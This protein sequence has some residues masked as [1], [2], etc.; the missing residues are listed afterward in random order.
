MLD[1]FLMA[2]EIHFVE[3]KHWDV[4]LGER[5]PINC[6]TATGTFIG[7]DLVLLVSVL[8]GGKLIGFVFKK[9]N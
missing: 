7:V 9:S 6:L 2:Q 1:F 8:C 4:F 3:V 5:L